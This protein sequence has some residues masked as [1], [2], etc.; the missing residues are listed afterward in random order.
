MV[1]NDG[2]TSNFGTDGNTKSVYTKLLQQLRKTDNNRGN[3]NINCN[4]EN[5]KDRNGGGKNHKRKNQHHNNGSGNSD[6]NGNS[7]GNNQD[8]S[9]R[10]NKDPRKNE[11]SPFQKCKNCSKMHAGRC[12]L[13][14][15][16]GNFINVTTEKHKFSLSSTRQ[17]SQ[18]G[19]RIGNTG[20]NEPQDK[21]SLC[22]QYNTPSC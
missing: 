9:G 7:N 12:K 19:N 3:N 8:T 13:P 11:S 18:S 10:K 1:C 22:Q 15:L 2:P 5:S 20:W 16:D 6:D 14:L 21:K 4:Q 17:G